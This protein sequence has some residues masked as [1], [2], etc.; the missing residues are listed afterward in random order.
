M[1]LLPLLAFI[2]VSAG[3]GAA[4]GVGSAYQSVRPAQPI[5]A[6]ALLR[7]AAGAEAAYPHFE[8]DATTH[9]FG[10]ME[11]GSTREHSFQ[12]TNTGNMPLRISVE[13]TS[14]KCTVGDVDGE[15][16]KPGQQV[17]VT[18]SWIAKSAPG[19]FRQTATLVT[20]DPRAQRV[21]LSVEGRVTDVH[22]ISP[23][24]WFFDRLNAGEER[25]ASLYVMA[26]QQE[27][28]EVT[29]AK[30]DGEE[31]SEW[32]RVE[33]VPVAKNELPDATALSGVRIDVTTKS[34]LPLG[35]IHDWVVLKTN[36]E[37][38][39]E[40]PPIPILGSVVGDMHIRGG[41]AWNKVAN[42][43]FLGNVESSEGKQVT[44][45]LSVKGEHAEEIKFE[46]A[47]CDPKE[48]EIEIGEARVLRPGIVHLPLTVRI[49]PGLPPVIRNGSGQGEAGHV[50]LRSN[51]PVSPEIGFDVRYT[52]R[53]TSV[54]P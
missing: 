7:G 1:R 20:N 52:I 6:M 49:P 48:I 23:Q 39:D 19:P 14:C 12:V 17:P 24:Q 43:V 38:A 26:F 46:V 54:S 27:D 35:K 9:D 32:Y 30:M 25:T 11:R 28:W 45:F 42:S 4:I 3:V 51:H 2:A 21:E 36:L 16:I 22:G 40:F 50:V 15:R 34:G 10:S 41:A 18:L 13:G 53:R 33:V 37:G 29:S 8:I 47:R 44:L 5:A 31:A